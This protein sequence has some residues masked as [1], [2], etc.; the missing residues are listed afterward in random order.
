MD[1]GIVN[2]TKPQ[3]RF[4]FTYQ[5][6]FDYELCADISDA[7]HYETEASA[8]T[9]INNLRRKIACTIAEEKIAIKGY[10]HIK[11]DYSLSAWEIKGAKERL[12]S[13]VS[14]TKS[15]KDIIVISYEVEDIKETNTINVDKKRLKW[16][17]L[18]N[19]DP[20]P[21]GRFE[22]ITETTGKHYCKICGLKL[23]NIPQVNIKPIYGGIICAKCGI[24]IGEEAKRAWDSMPDKEEIENEIFLHNI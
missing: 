2:F 5:G 12:K 8:K 17:T 1:N 15:Y 24:K 23:K 3:T 10:N 16:V 19:G 6:K 21:S 14:F 18:Y 13:L 11:K 4:G 20:F 9:S 22:I 7:K